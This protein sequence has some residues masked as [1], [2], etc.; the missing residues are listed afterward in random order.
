MGWLIG[1]YRAW[2]WRPRCGGGSHVALCRWL[3]L[4]STR[5]PAKDA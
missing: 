4:D 1:M 3:G 5:C 2:P